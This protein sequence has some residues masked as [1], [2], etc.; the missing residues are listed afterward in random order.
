MELRRLIL[1]SFLPLVAI[2]ATGL[3]FYSLS[4][5]TY[6]KCPNGFEMQTKGQ[7]VRCFKPE[8]I[9][10]QSPGQCPL[11]TLLTLDHDKLADQCLG[12]DKPKNLACP[13]GFQIEVLRGKD[14]CK[15]QLPAQIVAPLTK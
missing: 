2:G 14:R 10:Y 6:F 1:F 7:S 13:V 11:A 12:G 15:K 9:L 5:N 8:A 4:Q 3:S